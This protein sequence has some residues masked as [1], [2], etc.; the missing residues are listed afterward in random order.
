MKT[1]RWLTAL[2]AAALLA[3]CGGQASGPAGSASV[4]DRPAASA[5]F[6]KKEPEQAEDAPENSGLPVP[7]DTSDYS[8]WLALGWQAPTAEELG[9]TGW[10]L[11]GEEN[12]KGASLDLSRS[13]YLRM[14]TWADPGGADDFTMETDEGLWSL[15]E[16]NGETLLCFRLY[17]GEV[18]Y[19]E[20]GPS[21]ELLEFEMPVLFLPEEHYAVL[22]DAGQDPEWFMGGY[23]EPDGPYILLAQEQDEAYFPYYMAYGSM[24]DGGLTYLTIEVEDQHEEGRGFAADYQTFALPDPLEY[25]GLYAILQSYNERVTE[26]AQE[27]GTTH[28]RRIEILRSDSQV[29]SFADTFTLNREFVYPYTYAAGGGTN[30]PLDVVVYDMDRLKEEVISALSA[31]PSITMAE[32]WEQRFRAAEAG[33]IPFALDETGIWVF[34]GG[35]EVAKP[36]RENQRVRIEADPEFA[37]ITWFPSMGAMG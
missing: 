8:A 14:N 36:A 37:D 6:E 3:G 25:P 13:G 18:A 26:T 32:G 35:D 22:L 15:R 33:S 30:L 20:A 1:R 19:T 12:R 2:L 24:G 29:F 5:A 7:A 4:P 16:E 23:W 10:A 34:V 9:N 11:S 21:R 17:R 28:S 31:R 27:A